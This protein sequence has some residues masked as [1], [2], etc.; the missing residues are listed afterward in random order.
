MTPV[1]MQTRIDEFITAWRIVRNGWFVKSPEYRLEQFDQY[2]STFYYP[3]DTL[4][5]ISDSRGNF[6][7]DLIAPEYKIKFKNLCT[8]YDSVKREVSLE[9][10]RQD[11]ERL[12]RVIDE[13][14]AS[15][16]LRRSG[17]F[18]DGRRPSVEE[19]RDAWVNSF[20]TVV[21]L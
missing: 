6:V 19:V 18:A 8:D 11:N 17:L 10:R 16:G 21:V 13:A 14:M 12:N 5:N 4:R 3:I 7:F 2:S 15:P 20:D 9:R 1:E